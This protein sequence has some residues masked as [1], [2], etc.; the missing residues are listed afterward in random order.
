MTSNLG[1]DFR[2]CGRFALREGFE[3]ASKQVIKICHGHFKPEFLK[4]C[5]R[6]IIFRTA[7][8]EQLVKIIVTWSRRC[9]AVS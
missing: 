3:E 8:K 9:A 6:H 7:G 5:G 1:S 4:S 2:Q